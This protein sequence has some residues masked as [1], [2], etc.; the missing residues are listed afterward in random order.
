MTDT[1]LTAPEL[2]PC[3]FCGGKNL[4]AGYNEF[5]GLVTLCAN[6]EAHGPSS[7]AEKDQ[8]LSAWNTRADLCTPTDE[9][10]KALVNAAKEVAAD[11]D[12]MINLPVR[13]RDRLDAALRGIGEGK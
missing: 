1:D 3:P 8:I 12:A 11:A 7:E 9:R 13:V 2:K 5:G 4:Y 10:V 6:C